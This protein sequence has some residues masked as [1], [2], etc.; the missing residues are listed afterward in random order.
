[1]P[2]R[3]PELTKDKS[4]VV[5]GIQQSIVYVDSILR[6]TSGDGVP[7]PGQRS[8]D[9]GFSADLFNYAFNSWAENSSVP[10]DRPAFCTSIWMIHALADHPNDP[11]A[12]PQI[13]VNYSQ[14]ISEGDYQGQRVSDY[15]QYSSTFQH[16]VS[17]IKDGDRTYLADLTFCQFVGQDRTI[18]EGKGKSPLSVDQSAVAQQLLA[19]NYIELTPQNLPELLRLT[20]TNGFDEKYQHLSPESCA[21]IIQNIQPSTPG[22]TNSELQRYLAAPVAA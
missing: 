5:P 20:S 11:E 3:S 2:P 17:I 10:I 1:M 9:C 8:Q 19:E 21:Q 15:Q 13:L 6:R 12:V 14:A 7:G 16:E 18:S 22:F 4:V